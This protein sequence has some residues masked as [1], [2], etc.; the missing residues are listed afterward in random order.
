MTTLISSVIIFSLVIII[1]ELGHFWAAKSV[2]ITVHEFSIGMG[3]EI[4]SI[5]KGE[6]K[7]SIKL[8]P[9]GGYVKMEGEDDDSFS[10]DSFNSKSVL[11]RLKVIIMGPLMNFV[12]ALIVFV[13]VIGIYGISGNTLE[14]IDNSLNEYEAGLRPGDKIVKINDEKVKYWEEIQDEISSSNE[15]YEITVERNDELHKYSVDHN[16]RYMIGI[17]P[18]IID[19]EYTNTIGF[20]DE[21]MPAYKEGLRS[22]DKI[23]SINGNETNEWALTRELINDSSGNEI[24]IQVLRDNEKIGV[25][26]LPKKQITLG[27]YTSTQKS[28]TDI[29]GGS[30]YK[31]TYYIGL[32]FD[33]IV[34]LVSGQV[35]SEAIAGPVGI[36]NMIGQ[37]ASLGLYPLL[38]LAAFISINLGFVN[39]LPIPALDGSRILF[40]IVEKIRGKRIP[41]DKE[42]YIHF[43]GFVLL[44]AL[45][46]FV[47]YN[48]ISKILR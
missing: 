25:E 28:L 17:S 3:P 44:M 48:D 20:I 21:T 34:M 43:V 5:Q 11:Q 47:L 45:M 15:S 1:H 26:V 31:T 2:G 38:N 18:E 30:L 7:Y 6:T 29:L 19:D 9:I 24:N 36:V 16:Y 14:E 33:F 40:L 37:A 10:K 41:P 13:F 46:F 22:G 4:K 35:G 39:L 8:F 42:G 12:L 23:I 32:M 27:F